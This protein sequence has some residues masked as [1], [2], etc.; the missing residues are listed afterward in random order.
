MKVRFIRQQ[1]SVCGVATA[2]HQTTPVVRCVP[3]LAYSQ[4]SVRYVFGNAW[5]QVDADERDRVSSFSA[6]PVGWVA[7][8]LMMLVSHCAAGFLVVDAT[9]MHSLAICLYLSCFAPQLCTVVA[10]NC[11]CVCWYSTCLV[12][13]CLGCRRS[14][15]LVV[16]SCGPTALRL[17]TASSL[18]GETMR[19]TLQCTG[20]GR[21]KRCMAAVIG[22]RGG[23]SMPQ[24][25][26]LQCAALG[27]CYQAPWA[28]SVWAAVA[29]F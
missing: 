8:R 1:L 22:S 24:T 14:R 11:A 4:A 27:L 5:R 25:S 12:C 23:L 19:T 26:C 10:C 7:G 20:L 3:A 6:G 15:G 16:L 17:Q 21:L 2:Q 29:A 13:R 9:P 18:C 28:V